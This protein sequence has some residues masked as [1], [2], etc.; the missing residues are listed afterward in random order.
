M[1]RQKSHFLLRRTSTSA[2]CYLQTAHYIPIGAPEHISATLLI[3]SLVVITG[4]KPLKPAL[5]E[6]PQLCDRG[7]HQNTRKAS[8]PGNAPQPGVKRQKAINGREKLASVI[9]VAG[10]V[11]A[12]GGAEKG[13]QLLFWFYFFMIFGWSWFTELESIAGKCLIWCVFKSRCFAS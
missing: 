12:W 9:W 8:F 11:G 6:N 7:A 3:F 13:T 1:H 4:N 2:V 10:G 5:Q